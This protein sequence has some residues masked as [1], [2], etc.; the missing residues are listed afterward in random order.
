MHSRSSS[1]STIGSEPKVVTYLS[2]ELPLNKLTHNTS[3]YTSEDDVCFPIVVSPGDA[4][5]DSDALQ[6]YLVTGQYECHLRLP[7]SKRK[8]L[9]MKD[10]HYRSSSRVTFF[11][12]ESGTIKASSLAEL[13]LDKYPLA[14]LLSLDTYWIDF[15]NPSD[16]DLKWIGKIFQI[17]PLTIEDIQGAEIR[18]K[19]ESFRNYYFVNTQ[20]FDVHELDSGNTRSVEKSINFYSIVMK[21]CILTFHYLPIHHPEK[22]MNR[23]E[24]LKDHLVLSPDWVNYA[25]IDSI[26]DDFIPL[27]KCLEHESNSIDELVFILKQSEQADMLRRIGR[28]RKSLSGLLRILKPKADALDIEERKDIG[29][30]LGDV[31]DHVLAMIQSA[32]HFEGMLSRAHSNYLAQISIEIT[33]SSD[34]LNDLVAKLTIIGS[35]MLPMHV[36]AGLWGMNCPVPGK[37][38]DSLTWFFCIVGFMALMFVTSMIY[39]KKKKLL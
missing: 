6:N 18:E 1:S 21:N 24:Y 29:L 34:A 16:V 32:G 13:T 14:D 35:T 39:C 23:F 37:E 26:V 15:H 31:Q 17:H 19:C 28:A 20:T 36:I 9:I 25:L 5:F 4:P 33:H 11:S 22:V 3:D 10:S 38:T 7:T 30:Y 27:E 8:S 12:T 2:E